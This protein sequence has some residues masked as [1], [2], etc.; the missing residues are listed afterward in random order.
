MLWNK[1]CIT[2]FV[3]FY[4]IVV[5]EDMAYVL[6]IS[7]I[8]RESGRDPDEVFEEI[9]QE[10]ERNADILAPAQGGAQ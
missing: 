9:R 2:L 10:R 4:K 1:L 7:E 3:I 6:S 5:Q 8:I